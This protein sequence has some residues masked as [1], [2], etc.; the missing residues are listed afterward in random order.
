MLLPLAAFW[1]TSCSPTVLTADYKKRV[2]APPKRTPAS[3]SVPATQR[4]YKIDGKTYYPI[5]S[6][7]GFIQEGIASWYGDK[8]HGR[9]TSNG[10]VYDMHTATAAHKTLPMNTQLLVQNLENNKETIV[11]INDRGPFV[12]GRIIDLSLLSANELD[13]TKKGTARIRITALGEAVTFKKGDETFERFSPH[14]DFNSGEFYVQIGSF[15]E[16]KNAENLK[17]KMLAWGKK[18]VIRTYDEPGTRYYRV[19]VR[20]GKTLRYA[21]RM[22]RA[23]GA[24][25]FPGAF[26]V[27]R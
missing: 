13:I 19:Q 27:A 23:L 4:P 7:H 16:K 11:R 22:E 24:S 15:T 20:A 6:S 8:F 3:S 18:T 26:V 1:I 2:T 10:E 9:K 25:G 5:P 14:E 17:D 12:K 21:N